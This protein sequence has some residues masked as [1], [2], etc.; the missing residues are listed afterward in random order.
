MEL[1]LQYQSF[2]EYSGL[3]SFRMDWFHS[4]LSKGLSRAFSSTTIRKHPLLPR[5]S[6]DHSARSQCPRP[7]ITAKP[8]A[9]PTKI[10]KATLGHFSEASGHIRD[11]IVRPNL[12]SWSG[13]SPLTLQPGPQSTIKQAQHNPPT[14]VTFETCQKSPHHFHRQS[15]KAQNPVP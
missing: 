10:L 12:P 2:N 11:N 1:Q 8:A 4:L 13:A 5:S 7:T 14:Q 9:F 3:I 15:K 6:K